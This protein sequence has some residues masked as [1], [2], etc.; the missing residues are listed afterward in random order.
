MS[1]S[2][3]KGTK[4]ETD[5]VRYL[6]EAG[7][8]QAERRTL[9]GTQDRGDIAGVPGVVIEVKNCARQEL[10]GWVVEAERERDNDGATLGVVWHKK[11]GTTDPGRW[12]VTMSGAQFAQLLREQQGL[13]APA[14][15]PL[16]RCTCGETACESDLCDCDSAPCP[17]DH[18]A[19]ALQGG[20][21]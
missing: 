17:V 12:F 7:F 6:R 4:A 18:A 13:D 1:Q 8:T 20:A 15:E 3:A 2:K 19:E 21:A 11:R 14:A 9:N 16:P 5:V 10:P